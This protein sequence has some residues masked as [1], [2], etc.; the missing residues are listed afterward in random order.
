MISTAGSTCDVCDDVLVQFI[1]FMRLA[2]FSGGSSSYL[3]RNFRFV[4]RVVWAL[5]TLYEL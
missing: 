2:L 3:T 1:P 5:I 4:A